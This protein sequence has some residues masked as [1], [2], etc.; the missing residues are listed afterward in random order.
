MNEFRF[1]KS[2]FKKK[3][4]R[5]RQWAGEVTVMGETW[6]AENVL[7]GESLG[8]LWLEVHEIDGRV[9]RRWI[10]VIPLLVPT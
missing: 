4:N 1:Y 2:L 5:G 10:S 3:K 6:N 8:S 7:M 9:R